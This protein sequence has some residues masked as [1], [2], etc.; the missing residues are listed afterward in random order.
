M[1]ARTA[2]VVGGALGIGRACVEVLLE[3]GWRVVS[4]D[5]RHPAAP[6]T[7]TAGAHLFHADAGEQAS[8]DALVAYAERLGPVG[9][10]VY[11]AGFERHGSVVEMSEDDWSKIIDINLTGVFRLGKAVIPAM[12][13]AGGGSYVA[14]SSAQGFATEP[15]AG[16]YAA[17]KGAVAS[18]VRGMA[19]DH[20]GEGIRVNALAPGSVDTPLLRANA[21]A[22]NADDPEAV[23]K[24]W[25]SL[26]ALKRLAAPHEIGSIVA[27]LL[28]DSTSFVTG[29]T[30][31]ADGGLLASY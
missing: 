27:M 7:D 17:T 12:R 16:P 11:T 6:R 1:T 3:R 9:G 20:G 15:G 25:A 8:L 5:V 23:L 19:L 22:I 28:D 2:V 24:H 29:A 4:G 14:M 18:L 31:L 26:H 13:R 21:V 30:W 10:A